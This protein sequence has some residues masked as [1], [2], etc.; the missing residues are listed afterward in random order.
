[1]TEEKA[2]GFRPAV[3]DAPGR[4]DFL[5]GVADYS[6]SLVLET[7]TQARTT[8]TLEPRD[9]DE[10]CLESESFGAALVPLL[11]L[12]DLVRQAAAPGEFRAF[13]D[14]LKFPAWARYPLGC[15]IVLALET[16]WFSAGGFSLRIQSRVPGNLGVSSS[17][18]L[19]IATLRAFNAA[20]GLG[21]SSLALARLG[22]RAENLIVGAPCGLM[23][24]LASSCGEPGALLPIL[25][26]PD[27][28]SPAVPLPK[29]LVIA[30]WP[31]GVKH[32]V[33]GSPY[34][35]AR[36]ASFMGKRLVE[37]MTGQAWN[38]ASEIPRELF[39]RL[40]SELPDAM[41]G[42]DFLARH[43]GID[44]PLS[45][46]EPERLYPVRAATRFPI[47]ENARAQ[48]ALEVLSAYDSEPETAASELREIL[49]ASHQ[50][51][52]AMQL[53]SPETD[54]MVGRLL[55]Q[56]VASGFIGGRISGGGG[57]GTVVVLLTEEAAD[58]FQ[59]WAPENSLIH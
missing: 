48:R 5:G 6:G 28:L 33:A 25:C 35:T 56:P 45:R 16:G 7:P 15:L 49:H 54:A 46:V 34:A 40:E 21:C 3:A 38:Y 19:E 29:G 8:V 4:L 59:T 1:V 20:A 12:R 47:D 17:A 39:H 55:E 44:D 57:G 36:T 52:G 42:R 14:G 30:G 11:P 18:A 53:G 37:V 23:D 26:R 41:P 32:H 58:R 9:A 43:A 27:V 13:L 22:Q 10:G 31:S 50:D 2:R 24:Q 51:Y